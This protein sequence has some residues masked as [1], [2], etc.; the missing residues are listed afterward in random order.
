[1]CH[2]HKSGTRVLSIV[3]MADCLSQTVLQLAAVQDDL[4]RMDCRDGIEWH[5]EVPRIFDVDHQL[6]P[7]VRCYLTDSAEPLVTVGTNT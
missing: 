1:M 4:L 6:R 2:E 3:G 7:A 5:N